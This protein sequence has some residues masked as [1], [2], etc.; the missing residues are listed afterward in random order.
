M[1]ELGNVKIANEV[2]AIVAGIAAN[3][4]PGVYSMIGSVADEFNKII[5]KRK[6]PARGI[7]VEVGET[8]C[9][10]DAYLTMEY[11]V[12]IPEIAAEVQKN[13]IRAINDMTGLEVKEVNIYVQGI[14]LAKEDIKPEPEIVTGE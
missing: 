12:S 1:T 10:I 2:V 14:H 5:G 6:N 8:E 11:G 4:I 9:S 13:I 3:E 7:K